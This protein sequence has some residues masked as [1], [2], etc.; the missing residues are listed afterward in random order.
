MPNISILDFKVWSAKLHF[1]Q[2]FID[3]FSVLDLVRALLVIIAGHFIPCNSI[4]E[5]MIKKL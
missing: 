3:F 1:S 2:V 5:G 4:F